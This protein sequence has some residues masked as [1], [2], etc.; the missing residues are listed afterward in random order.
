MYA[1]HIQPIRLAHIML[2]A[3]QAASPLCFGHD[4]D[5]AQNNNN[6]ASNGK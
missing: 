1:A 5:A 3:C 6:P 2:S 4:G